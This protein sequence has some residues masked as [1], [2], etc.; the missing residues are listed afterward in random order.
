GRARSDLRGPIRWILY[1]LTR[2]KLWLTGAIAGMLAQN[3][4]NGLVPVLVGIAF[5]AILESPPDRERLTLVAIVLLAIVLLRGA[6]DLGGQVAS[7]VIA[8][9][10]ERDTRD[11]LFV[12]LLGKSQTFH[13][14]QQVGDLMARAANDVRQLNQMVNPGLSLIIDSL[15]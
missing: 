15:T 2:Y 14:R 1:H 9:R 4:L 7:E 3:L 13:N 5:D 6:F 8:K 10:L 12:S 11:E